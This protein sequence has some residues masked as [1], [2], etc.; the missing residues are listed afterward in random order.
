MEVELARDV[1][2]DWLVVRCDDQVLREALADLY[3]APTDDGAFAKR[4]PAGSVTTT[5]LDH[6]RESLV[7][8]LRQTAR[9]DAVPWKEALRDVIRRLDSA[10][11]EW[12]L[13]GS[14]A[15]AVRGLQVEPRD[16]DLVVAD[17]DARRTGEAFEDVL[18]EPAVE[19]DGWI[20]RWF[21]R[22]W[23]GARVEWVAGVSNGVDQ[24]LPS[25]F[26]PAAAANLAEI[27]WEQTVIRVPS[28]ELQHAV[29][30]R[31][32][33]GDRVALIETLWRHS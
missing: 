13:A 19:T 21:G 26:G 32:G 2:A 5:I 28:L 30:A 31:R 25:D 11:I 7:P 22:A 33:L 8:M 10:K 4:F 9:L 18:I 3:F 15:L 6:F 16:L 1:E 17:A 12:W 14:A 24:P 23:V 20:S 27:E 29:S